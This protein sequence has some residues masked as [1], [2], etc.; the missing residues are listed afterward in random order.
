MENNNIY[1]E[2]QIQVLEGL[3]AV[4]KR[5]GMYIGSTSIRG[6]H[7]LVYEIVDNSIDEALA[8]FCKNI[9]V[10]I[11][12]DNSITV[13]D[14]GRGMPVGMHHK[15]KIP[16][17]EVIM[18]VLHAGGKFGGGAYKVSGGL[19]GVGSSVVNALSVICE[20]EVKVDGDIWKQTFSKG[21]TTSTLVNIGTTQ[22]HGTKV[23]FTPDPE[24]FEEIDFDFETLSQR[25]RELAFLN[26]GLRITLEDER[27][28]KKQDFLYEGG[29][30]SFV[31]YLNRNKGTIHE[32]I[33]MEG[34]KDDYVVE[35]AL[36]YNDT[37]TE[38]IFSFANNIDT[39]EGGTHLVGFKSALTRVVN[40]YAKKFG[41]LKENDKNLSGEDVREGLT[42]VISIKLTDPQFEGQ[43]KTKLGNSEVRGIVDSIV[44]ES[45]SNVLEEDPQLGKNIID[46]ALN[47]ARAREA[48]KKA[49]EFT[50]RKSVLESTTLPGKLSD[51]AS[52][53]PM[54]CEIYLVEGDSAG[55]SAKQGRDRR[56][57]AILPL[58]G[59]IMNV[60]KQRIDKM[61]A[62]LE[63]R[64]MITA[65]GAGIGKDFDVKKI[66]YD[67]IIIMTDADVDG[68]HI[69]TLLLTFFYRYMK[70]LV[71]QGHVYV[72]QPPLYK[73]SKAK[74]E[75]YVYTD[76]ELKALLLEIGGKDNNT[77]IQR[78][79]G[80]GEMDAHQLWDTTM[81][82]EERILLQ[83]QVEDAM[84]ADEIFTILMGDKVEP[85]REFIQE[86]A[87]G[88][89]NLDI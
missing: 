65:F 69:R 8:G 47:A 89:L 82:P 4:R 11:H 53:D 75:H 28:E 84:A 38:N 23:F 52:K 72:A 81:N 66:R 76:K 44:G 77:D 21:K 6:L 61:L 36:Q 35:I 87:K 19:H 55:G 85:R 49:R 41:F 30:K 20:V 73:V 74:K 46:K 17:V 15:M 43:T 14:D 22:E 64:A 27:E 31:D 24:I 59:K 10:I 12:K 40:D 3:E 9:N 45:I 62:S 78:Y 79:K 33:Y 18:T 16:T 32:T 63:I 5:P 57:Q 60:E 37:Y 34:N 42:A 26:K 7:H 39:V 48:A 86:N 67:R 50:R 56:F 58:K 83:V 54:E 13:I 25:L 71:E 29:I 68:A 80:L 51:C 70:E 2:S 88:V 1:D